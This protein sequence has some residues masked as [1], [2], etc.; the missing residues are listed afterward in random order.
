M[1]IGV[2]NSQKAVEMQKRVIETTKEHTR[3]LKKAM[4]DTSQV[5]RCISCSSVGST[6]IGN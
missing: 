4:D 3:L 6:Q 5:R 1:I 2:S